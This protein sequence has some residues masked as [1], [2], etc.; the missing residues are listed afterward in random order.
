VTW[1]EAFSASHSK[2][3]RAKAV[4][5]WFQLG[6]LALATFV[7]AVTAERIAVLHLRAAT[8]DEAVRWLVRMLQSGSRDAPQQWARA[9]PAAQLA[10]I[11]EASRLPNAEL[12]LR[13]LMAE[14]RDESLARLGG[15][16]TSA[17]LASTLGLLGGIVTLARGAPESAGLDALRA[18]ALE[19]LAMHEA[20]ATMAIGVAT[21]AFCFQALSLLRVAAEKRIAQAR[22]LARA[23]GYAPGA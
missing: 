20:I 23:V 13:E 22:Q 1:C 6:Q 19:R 18:G 3:L 9:R 17:T 11:I 10:R 15:L 4:P 14:L 5:S 2:P 21:S 7:I 12:E 16:R 8:S